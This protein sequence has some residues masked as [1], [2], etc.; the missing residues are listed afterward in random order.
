MELKTELE[1]QRRKHDLA[2]QQV[3]SLK[4]SYSEAQ[5]RISNREVEIEALQAKLASAMAEIVASEQAVACMRSDLKLERSRCRERDEER[6]RNEETLRAQLRDSEDRLRD[7]E[8]KLL[9]KTQAL[10]F[11]EQQQALQRDQRKEVQRLQEKLN[12][13]TG[14]L[15]AT[16]EAQALR[17]ERER[18]ERQSLEEKLERERQGLNRRLTESEEQRLKAE[19]QLQEAQERIE[20]LLRGADG[21]RTDSDIRMEILHLQQDLNEQSDLTETLRESIRALEEERDCLTCHCQELVNQIA[22]ADREV[23]KLQAQLKTEESDY[24]SLE[25]SYNRMSEEFARISRV[26]R[27]KEEDIRQT[28]ETYEELMRKK[29]QDFNEAL[30]KMAALGNSLEETEH[31]LK[32]TE[33][34]LSQTGHGEVETTLKEKLTVAE[35]RITELEQNLKS[36]HLEYADLR[37]E[38]CPPRENVLHSPDKETD[39]DE[40]SSATSFSLTR[41]SSESDVSFAKRQRIRFSNIQ[42]QRYH[43]SQG[44]EKILMENQFLDLTEEGGHEIDPETS[45]TGDST[46]D[47]SQVNN[48]LSDESV[49]CC[50]GADTHVSV[51]RPLESKLRST[52]QKKTARNQSKDTQGA[53]LSPMEVCG[54]EPDQDEPDSCLEDNVINAEYRKALVFVESCQARVQEILIS[55]GDRT[56]TEAQLQTLSQIQKDLSSATVLMQQAKTPALASKSEIDKRLIKTLAK[57]L[58]FEANVLQRMSSALQEPE[59]EVMRSVTQIRKEAE[60]RESGLFTNILVRKLLVENLLV[61]DLD[62]CLPQPTNSSI[63]WDNSPYQCDRAIHNACVNAELAYILQTLKHTDPG[64]SEDLQISD[65]SLRESDLDLSEEADLDSYSTPTD[66]SPY[67]QQI[68]R[69]EALS[70]AEDMVRRHLADAMEPCR[71]ESGALIQ[72]GRESLITELTRQSEF[73]HRLS[74]RVDKAYEEGSSTFCQRLASRIQELFDPRFLTSN[75]VF[76]YEALSHAQVAYVA[77]RMRDDQQREILLCQETRRKMAG[78]VQE[79]AQHVSRIE[80]QFQNDLKQ[81]RLNF[82]KTLKSLREENETLRQEATVRITELQEQRE[83]IV[84]IKEAFQTQMQQI[85]KSHAEELSQMQQERSADG[86]ELLERAAGSQKKVET[87]LREM[88]GTEHRHQEHVRKLEHDFQRQ[89]EELE[90]THEEEIKKLHERYSQTILTLGKRFEAAEEETPPTAEEVHGAGPPREQQRSDQDIRRDSMS[91][92]RSR[93]QELELQMMSMR[94]E[95]ENKPPDGD[96][97]SLSAKYQRDFDSLKV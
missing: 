64:E 27:E 43:Q 4:R 42:C 39:H 79:H 29:D 35:N 45:L 46:Q 67:T 92:L 72:A 25:R 95:L 21:N 23:G 37:M 91:L 74:Q 83:H 65:Q 52:G 41:S 61:Y 30:V 9:E 18:K 71:I 57:M 24:F 69:E 3:S 87:L 70:L 90:T 60:C 80:R 11:L 7:V 22:E 36:L 13:V 40:P 47:Y 86:R 17:E 48:S 10:R 26:L 97:V 5:D 94:D 63:P 16:E 15:I 56:T 84:E 59:S 34:L 53:D 32:A 20:V 89:V 58:A 12:E 38:R 55:H 1:A 77:C 6:D 73:L 75:S 50:S 49:Q 88:D 81:E 85:R 2:Y 82:S 33:E 51:I 62:K 93:V 54:D 96:V 44:L 31:R 8:A 76:M 68:E 14:R 28:K 78:L 19:E 66:L